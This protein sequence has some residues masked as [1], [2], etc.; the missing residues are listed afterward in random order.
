MWGLKIGIPAHFILRAQSP[1]RG[2]LLSGTHNKSSLKAQGCGRG[3]LY[4][5]HLAKR[6]K[7]RTDSAQGQHRGKGC[8]RLNVEPIAWQTHTRTMLSSSS[9]I[10]LTWGLIRRVTTPNKEK[11][12]RMWRTGENTS[13]KGKEGD[14]PRDPRRG[15]GSSQEPEKR[16]EDELI[17]KDGEGETLL[18][19]IPR[20]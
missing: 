20:R 14:R 7:K 19:L 5:W 1:G 13:I 16:G 10:T 3:R 4:A 15:G 11:L 8:H 17:K 12:T 18:G 2:A 9:P 6:P